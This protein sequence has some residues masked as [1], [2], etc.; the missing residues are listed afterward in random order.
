M[1][2]AAVAA[3]VAAIEVTLD[4]DEDSCMIS[5]EDLNRLWPAS[6]KKHGNSFFRTNKL[7]KFY[8]KK[9]Y[10]QTLELTPTVLKFLFFIILCF[11]YAST[12]HLKMK[13]KIICKASAFLI[14]FVESCLP[15]YFISVFNYSDRIDDSLITKHIR[16]KKSPN[17][18]L[19]KMY[20]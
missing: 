18:P 5:L 17:L 9:V 6:L 1:A 8:P 13:L 19:I 14:V 16:F 11:V 10:R 15:S 12:F 7:I 4:D 2:A 3:E 20:H